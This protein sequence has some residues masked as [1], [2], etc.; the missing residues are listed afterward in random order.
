MKIRKLGVDFH[1]V[2]SKNPSLF[3][4]IISEAFLRKIEVHIISGGPR[5]YIER[6]L[7]EHHILYHKLWCIIDEP[8]INEKTRFFA[9]ES[10][11]VDDVLWDSAKA[12]YC[13]NH[14]IDIHI[15]DSKIYGSYFT[16][17]YCQYVDDLHVFTC[18]NNTISTNHSVAQIFT[19][20]EQC[21]T[22]KISS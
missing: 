1:G 4:E 19:F 16:T 17:S 9:D 7:S 13:A 8:E 18:G 11:K 12:K 2:I 20:L 15:D 22:T 10:F 5:K 21:A 3:K 14:N 6:Y